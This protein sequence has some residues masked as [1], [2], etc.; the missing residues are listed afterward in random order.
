MKRVLMVLGLAGLLSAGGLGF[1][2]STAA[3]DSCSY[4]FETCIGDAQEAL[5]SCLDS[6]GTSPKKIAACITQTLPKRL[7]SDNDPLFRFH[8]WLA[9]LRVLEVDEIKTVPGAPRSHAFVERLIGTIRREFLTGHCFGARAISSSSWKPTKRITT[10]IAVT[11]D[12]PGSRRLK[13]AVHF[14]LRP[15]ASIRITGTDTATASFR[16]RLPPELEFA[17]HT[18]TPVE[19]DMHTPDL[20]LIQ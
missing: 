20:L 15:H 11:P 6:A 19:I 18:P 5:S 13:G 14:R 17:T 1:A 2:R 16:P 3:S 4:E 10:G 7:S 9:N 12:W 8:R